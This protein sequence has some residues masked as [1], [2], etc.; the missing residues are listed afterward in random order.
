[1]V[2]E[3]RVWRALSRSFIL[4]V[5]GMEHVVEFKGSLQSVRPDSVEWKLSYQVILV[6]SLRVSFR[7]SPSR[8]SRRGA[9][10]NESD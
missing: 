6:P 1:M 7:N 4:Q 3:P 8:S 10:V 9:V 5:T 2:A